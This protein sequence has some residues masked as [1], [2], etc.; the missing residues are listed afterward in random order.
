MATKRAKKAT[1]ASSRSA[2][3]GPEVVH[4][5]LESTIQELAQVGYAALRVEDV[6]QRAQVHKTTIYRRYPD[7][8]E[9][10]REALRQAFQTALAI[11]D[12]GSLR[13][14]LLQVGTALVETFSSD[15]G[16]AMGLMLMSESP[17]HVPL[18]RI[19][20]SL[21]SQHDTIPKA[22]LDNAVARGEIRSSVDGK[23]L[24]QA[25]TGTIHYHV[26]MLH[27]PPTR[28]VLEAI[29]DLLLQGANP[30]T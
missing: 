5:I 6:A 17:D 25:L 11:P 4:D 13:S 14:D 27:A 8:A 18:R 1:K 9:L 24:L 2:L 3:R 16:R 23:L 12:T 29:V 20:E 10:V 15:R 7:K 21:R 19:M 28:K 26:N 30:Q 22:V